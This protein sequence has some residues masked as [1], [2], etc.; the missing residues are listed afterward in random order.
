MEF[1]LSET[2][3]MVRASAREFLE[4][5]AG[6]GAAREGGGSDFW[7]K[8]SEMGWPGLA[9]AEEHG[10]AGMGMS[11]LGV[12]IEQWG[13]HLAPGPLF[14]SAVLAAPILEESAEERV[15]RE[16]LPQM[17][18]GRATVA[19]AV[20]EQSASW[21]PDGIRATSVK[22]S[23]GWAITGVK[24]FVS[25]GD[26]ASK[27]LVAARTGDGAQDISL[28]LID[29]EAEG[30]TSEP[31][32]HASSTPTAVLTLNETYADAARLVGQENGGWPLI[33]SMLLRGAAFR[34]VQ[35]AGLGRQVLE[36]TAAYVKER[37]Q[38][39]VPVGSFQAIQHHLA[40]MAVSVR[41]VEHLARQA[42]WS[43]AEGSP[44]RARQVSRAKFAASKLI[45]EVCWTAHQCHGAIG[46]T[47]EHDLHLYTRRALS[48]AA[49]FGDATWHTD[50]LADEL[51][52]SGD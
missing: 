30:I 43:V 52:S 15:K 26:E 4:R 44:G 24:H 8:V 22:T 41:R 49:E 38:F 14:E 45:P 46:F 5:E 3:E 13:V 39:G 20:L 42:V 7:T 11:A 2:E 27:L 12:L 9:I 10:G 16:I 21:R 31:L 50:R 32:D 25:Y 1:G 40:D 23:A 6:P 35:M 48:W 28:F 34:S 47:W 19:I 36:I 17:A 29:R 33:E 51:L 18:D 37:K